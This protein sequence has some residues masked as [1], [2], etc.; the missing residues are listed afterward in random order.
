MFENY[1]TV[2]KMLDYC[3]TDNSS[4]RYQSPSPN[5]TSMYNVDMMTSPNMAANLNMAE[6]QRHS[7][8]MLSSPPLAALHNMTEMKTPSAD[9]SPPGLQNPYASYSQSTLKQL[10]LAMSQSAT[11]HRITDILSR[12]LLHNSLGLSHLNSGMYLNSQAQ[13]ALKLAE[14]PGRPPIFWPGC[15]GGPTWRPNGK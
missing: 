1:G 5:M 15:V 2:P 3:S 14:L 11:S 7:A 12:P 6:A 9:S 13:N 4:P 10:G 8:F